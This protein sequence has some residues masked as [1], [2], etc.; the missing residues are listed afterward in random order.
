MVSEHILWDFNY[1]K[2]GF[3]YDPRYDLFS[4]M[5]KNVSFAAGDKVFYKCQLNSIG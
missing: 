5:C 4:A 3:F 2:F 1:F